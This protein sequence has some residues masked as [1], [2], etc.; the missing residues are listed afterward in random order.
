ML[1]HLGARTVAQSIE[2]VVRGHQRRTG[3]APALT[4][5]NLPDQVPLAVKIALYR[6]VQEALTTAWRHA[7]GAGVAILV[8]G[9]AA[10]LRLEVTD[11]GPG[12]EASL[13]EG[14]ED[15]LGL[16]DMRERVESL[17]GEFRIESA[18]GQGTRVIALLP[19]ATMENSDD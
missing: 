2:H 11:D 7:A 17:G 14:A 18:P 8:E 5:R 19:Y 4:A 6:I 1:P 10:G 9:T 16:F 15:Q 12:F 13:V 3:V